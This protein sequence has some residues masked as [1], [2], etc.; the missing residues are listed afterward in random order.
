MIVNKE[1]LVENILHRLEKP[2][3]S[4]DSGKFKYWV[5]DDLLPTQ[6]AIDISKS[7]PD[8]NILRKRKSLREYKRVGVDFE[9]YDKLMED[10]T[11]S[12]HDLKV[13]N[14]ICSVT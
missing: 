14:K 1:T 13:V 10:I 7:F 2:I 12:F 3:D 5:I 4:F 9:F 8:E 6:I 11:Y